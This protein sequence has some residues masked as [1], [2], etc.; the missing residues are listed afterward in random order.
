MDVESIVNEVAFSIGYSSLR[1]EQKTALLQ[2]LSGNNIFVRLPTGYG[3]SLCYI[4][5]PLIFDR[6][7]T[8]ISLSSVIL[9]VSPLVSLM[10]DQV[11]PLEGRET[12]FTVNVYCTA[13]PNFS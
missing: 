5:L 9:V 2:F 11:R 12:K 7:N 10:K 6:L 3:K 8:H 1:V 4:L 13:H